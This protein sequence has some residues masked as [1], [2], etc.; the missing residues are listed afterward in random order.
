MQPNSYLSYSLLAWTEPIITP[1]ADYEEEVGYC[2]K[3]LQENSPSE[4]KTLLHLGCGAGGYDFIFKRFFQVTGVDISPEMLAIARQTNPELTYVQGD[5]RN[6]Q[7]CACFDAVIIPDAI[8]YMVTLPDLKRVIAVAR[9]HLKPGG[10]LVIVGKTRE[11]FW[12]NNF[13]YRGGN[14]AVEITIFENNYILP[15]DPPTSY[16]ATLV[17]LIRQGGELTIHCDRHLL[18][19]F[20]QSDWQ[21]AFQEAGLPVKQTRWDGGYEPFLFPEGDYPMQVFVALNPPTVYS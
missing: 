2:V 1:P 5:M 3:I 21:S 10:V 19:L 4:L 11:E 15:G 17:Y 13:C 18:G 7:L 9:Q 16:E 14:D 12:H 6:L 20:A 8:D